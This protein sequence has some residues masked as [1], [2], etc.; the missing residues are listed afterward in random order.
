MKEETPPHDLFW[1]M[2]EA[3]DAFIMFMANENYPA[4]RIAE[5]VSV[6]EDHVRVLVDSYNRRNREK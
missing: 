1:K 3:R 5:Y 2:L 6:T 4:S